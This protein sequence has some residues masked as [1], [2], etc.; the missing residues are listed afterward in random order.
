LTRNSIKL[1]KSDASI[2]LRHAASSRFHGCIAP[3]S[4]GG[5][6]KQVF[7]AMNA[8][9]PVD[10]AVRMGLKPLQMRP[11]LQ[12]VVERPLAAVARRVLLR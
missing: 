11:G 12:R 5:L 8:H 4:I 10:L 2:A 3:E 9:Y 1:R 6:V 7:G